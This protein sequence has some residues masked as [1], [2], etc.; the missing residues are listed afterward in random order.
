MGQ[1]TRNPS[2]Q[3]P[4]RVYT[5]SQTGQRFHDST[6]FYR[7]LVGPWRSGKTVTLFMDFL[8]KSKSQAPAPDGFRYTRWGVVRNTYPELKSTT[9][10]TFLDWCPEG[11]YGVMKWEI[12]ITFHM[13][14]EDVR[15]EWVFMALDR[16]EDI[17]KL[18]SLEWTGALLNELREIPKSLLDALGGRVGQYPNK[19]MGWPTWEGIIGDTNPP[20]VDHW[21]PQWERKIE[22]LREHNTDLVRELKLF[23]SPLTGYSGTLEGDLLYAAAEEEEDEDPADYAFFHQPSGLAPDA[24]NLE[25]L[26]GGRKFYERL[27]RGKSPEFN[28]AYVH[29]KYPNVATG[30]TVYHEF[31]EYRWFDTHVPG[32][33]PVKI[34]WHVAA[35]QIPVIPG[36]TL[37]LPFDYGLTPCCLVCQLSHDG[38]LQVLRHLQA[39]NSGMRQFLRSDVIPTLQNQYQGHPLVLCGE[40]S[41]ETRAATDEKTGNEIIWEELHQPVE[42]AYTNEFTARRDA[43]GERLLDAPAGKPRLLFDPVGCPIL[44]RGF[45][46]DYRLRR[47]KVEGKEIYTDEVMDDPCT[48]GH[49][50]LQALCLVLKR[51]TKLDRQ[52]ALF[53]TNKLPPV[54]DENVGY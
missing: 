42:S 26:K 41:G 13:R 19:H 15:A 5:P 36:T 29:G 4:P 48:H 6:A 28:A 51:R 2:P 45:R 21:F 8:A 40:P 3:L 47:I 53:P 50:A 46:K 14:F 32:Q 54:A 9:I 43:V 23:N 35:E 44:L 52:R 39:W 16:A 22:A 12:P 7:F 38:Q 10:H 20:A 25:N 11:Q 24:E 33:P 1:R 49:D 31:Q 27:A 37:F 17:S 34:P 18:L 30:R